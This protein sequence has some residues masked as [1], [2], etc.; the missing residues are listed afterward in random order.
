MS[1]LTPAEMKEYNEISEA[2]K[3][4]ELTAKERMLWP[5]YGRRYA[6]QLE[7]E[8]R[9]HRERRAQD[10]AEFLAEK[11]AWAEA[12]DKAE[13]EGKPFATPEPERDFK[14]WLTLK[15]RA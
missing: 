3:V 13:V 7:R 10:M 11:K 14:T 8:G 15:G 12:R 5:E 4:R 2:A 6:A 9:E 1:D